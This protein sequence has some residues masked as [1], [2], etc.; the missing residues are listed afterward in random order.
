MSKKTKKGLFFEGV[1]KSSDNLRFYGVG[2]TYMINLKLE[3][4]W[5]STRSGN[6]I[7]FFDME[8]YAEVPTL[9]GETAIN[10]FVF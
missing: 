1:W 9:H 6:M 10:V 3:S 8:V 2:N 7:C 5:P 4:V